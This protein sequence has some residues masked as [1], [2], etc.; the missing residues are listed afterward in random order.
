MAYENLI[1]KTSDKFVGE[2][3]LNRPDQMNTFTTACPR[4]CTMLCWRWIRMTLYVL[5]YSR[6]PVAPFAQGSM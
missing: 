1:V 6:G 4:T 3:T 5:F 2:I